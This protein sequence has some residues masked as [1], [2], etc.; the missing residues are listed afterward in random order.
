[1]M[2]VIPR[3]VPI[4]QCG[5][6]KL[7]ANFVNAVSVRILTDGAGIGSASRNWL[8]TGRD[9]SVSFLRNGTLAD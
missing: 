1:M 6:S 4:N 8:F 2:T 3:R 5:K 7:L 9:M